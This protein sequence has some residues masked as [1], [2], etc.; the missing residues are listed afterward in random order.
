MRYFLAAVL[1]F[2][3][4]GVVAAEVP[5]L[6]SF[7][8]RLTTAGGD[9]V[10]G[11]HD[12]TFKLYD[13]SGLSEIWSETHHDVP[14]VAGLYN[15]MLGSETPFPAA[16]DF[17]EQYYLGV[18]VDGGTEMTPRYEL[19][20]SP[21][22]LNLQSMGAGDGQVLKWNAA[23]SRWQPGNDSTNAG[24]W[25][26]HTSAPY[27]YA[28]NNDEVKVY[29]AGEMF[30]FQVNG[31]GGTSVSIHGNSLNSGSGEKVGVLGYC[32]SLPS[33]SGTNYGVKGSATGG[34]TNYGVYGDVGGNPGYGVY[35][36]GGA[37]K[38]YGYL[39][40]QNCG[41]YGNAGT[42]GFY[43]VL[44]RVTP[45][46][47]SWYYGV[48]GWVTGGTGINY[49][50]LGDAEGDGI[51]YGVYGAASG[52]GTNYGVYGDAYGS[53]TN[54]AGYF[55]G[56]VHITGDL[57]VDGSYP[58][59]RGADADSGWAAVG[60]GELAL[61]GDIYHTGSIGIGTVY[62]EHKLHVEG[63][64]GGNAWDGH[65]IGYFKNNV[66]GGYAAGVYG[67]CDS[68][69]QYGYGGYFKGGYTGVKGEASPTG[70]SLYFGVSG[71]VHGGSGAN[72]G[73]YGSA[74]GGTTNY[75]LYCSG[76]GGY[77]GSW[78]HVSDRR[79]E[80]NI[81]PMSGI[82]NK[83]ML[84]N[85]VTYEMRTDEYDFMNF[86]EGRQYGLIAQELEQ[87]FP[88]L[89][90]PGVHPGAK[91]GDPP[92]EYK[93]IDYIPLTAIL[94]KAVQEQQ[95]IIEQLNAENEALNARIETI[96]AQVSKYLS[97]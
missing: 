80:K 64:E 94:I 70:G 7:Q 29:D 84:L 38:P 91:E 35:G 61:A 45:T 39:G 85:P 43:G 34:T 13:A 24:L 6:I 32:G 56:D 3:F 9:T 5:H 40:G 76:D 51:N 92:I 72:F 16:V 31:S 55:D 50:V 14:I 83:V 68:M 36:T 82:L 10:T 93:G 63:T 67:E 42:S 54:W 12:I 95:G 57:T 47:S 75:S 26:D 8:G 37:G 4:V 19:G 65:A 96:E 41:V 58:G 90:R 11:N 30:A 73:V 23:L 17:S 49:G 46:G 1:L 15:V 71:Y 97:E 66:T 33:G 60:G 59:G 88:E 21:Y 20:A 27:I 74:S 69:D 62:P 48:D 81:K 79:F 2:A 52:S 53:G 28:N 25:T 87:I 77:T 78:S 89:V 86:N 18:S 22:A 44:G